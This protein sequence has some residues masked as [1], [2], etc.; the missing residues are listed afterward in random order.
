MKK[1]LLAGYKRALHEMDFK[2]KDMREVLTDE[3]ISHNGKEYHIPTGSFI[4]DC[5]PSLLGRWLYL[6]DLLN[7]AYKTDNG[8]LKEIGEVMEEYEKKERE[9]AEKKAA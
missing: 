5:E 7:E 6:Q 4:V 9:K 8:L 1:K 3:T 2:N